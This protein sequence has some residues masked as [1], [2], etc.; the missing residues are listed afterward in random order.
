[1]YLSGIE[2]SKPLFA[3]L[4]LVLP[5]DQISCFSSGCAAAT[6][7]G[8][9]HFAIDPQTAK[10]LFI[11]AVAGIRFKSISA[12]E[13]CFCGISLEGTAHCIDNERLLTTP[14]GNDF[15]E[16]SIGLFSEIFSY[17]CAL[18]TDQTIVCWTADGVEYL[19]KS[20]AEKPLPIIL[21]SSGGFVVCVLYTDATVECW[22][23][24]NHLTP[25]SFSQRGFYMVNGAVGRFLQISLGEATEV[26]GILFD[27]SL[28][29]EEFGQGRGQ[30][31]VLPGEKFIQIN[32]R[33][34]YG[35]CGITR[36]SQ[37]KCWNHRM[38]VLC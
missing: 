29:R 7:N 32:T 30:L 11:S 13:A 31:Q 12:S 34:Y 37:I 2:C 6:R 10:P 22:W 24:N 23:Y 20:K 35:G 18:K 19:L 8:T 26:V 5:Q 1:M 9:T 28:V 33:G 15:V 27:G 14:S 3:S 21:V 36:D 4:I 17:A 25:V 16:V 38:Y